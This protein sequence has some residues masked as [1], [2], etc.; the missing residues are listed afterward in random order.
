[1]TFRDNPTAGKNIIIDSAL[2][3]RLIRDGYSFLPDHENNSLI[4]TQN[5]LDADIPDIGVEPVKPTK[6]QKLKN[7]VADKAGKMANW[8]GEIAKNRKKNANEVADWIL[9]QKDKVIKKILPTKILD[10]IELSKNTNYESNLITKS[11]R[12]FKNAI[13]EYEI[14]ILNKEDP[15]TQ[16]N[17]VNYSINALLLNKLRKLQGLKFNIGMEIL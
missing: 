3:S 10:L 5:I 14:K 8:L 11:G 1:M 6:F 17:L 16:M 15:L 12:A 2:Y 13:S 4:L 9:T 7:K